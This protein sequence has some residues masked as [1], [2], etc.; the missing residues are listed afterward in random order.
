MQNK[1][2]FGV[3]GAGVVGA[4]IAWHLAKRGHR[5][6][7]LEQGSVPNPISASFDQ[8]RLTRRMY[9]GQPHYAR[10][11][12][13]C[14]AAWAD[15][16][17]AMGEDHLERCGALSCSAIVGDWAD[18]GRKVLDE[19]GARYELLS[20]RDVEQRYPFLTPGRIRWAVLEPDGGVLLADRITTDLARLCAHADVEVRA[21]TRVTSVKKE[22]GTAVTETGDEFTFDK[23]V[24][25]TGAWIPQ[26]L[27]DLGSEVGP[28]RNVMVYF[29]PPAEF[30]EAWKKAP[31]IIDFGGPE[32]VWGA[33]PVR[34]TELKLADI[35]VRGSAEAGSRAEA[36]AGEL[37]T[38]RQNLAGVLKDFDRYRLKRSMVCWNHDSPDSRFMLKRDGRVVMVSACAAH[39]FKFGAWSASWAA[40][41]LAEEVPF[42]K[43]ARHMAGLDQ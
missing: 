38:I 20:G 14:Y 29:D 28:C 32:E 17:A 16:F 33:P 1:Q 4:G 35:G 11:M 40:K 7:L 36:S 25:A 39:G 23:L 42:D 15:L 12:D 41:A 19:V 43:A 5:V 18:R 24:V 37:S 22:T 31:A 34:G 2:H 27:P 13:E 3:I 9:P 26:V 6:T 21:N 30:A 8:H 10:L